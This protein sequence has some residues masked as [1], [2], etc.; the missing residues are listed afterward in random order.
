MTS[1][2][3]TKDNSGIGKSRFCLYLLIGLLLSACG[4][5]SQNSSFNVVA[6]NGPTGFSLAKM[7]NENRL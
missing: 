3:K 4:S 2:I 1:V 5:E 6:L 7:I